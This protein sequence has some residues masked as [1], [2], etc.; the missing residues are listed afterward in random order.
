MKF[1][2]HDFGTRIAIYARCIASMEKPLN[3]KPKDRL[4]TGER[5]HVFSQRLAPRRETPDR[6]GASRFTPMVSLRRIFQCDFTT[7][8]PPLTCPRALFA[9]GL[10]SYLWCEIVRVRRH[11][12]DFR[13]C[14]P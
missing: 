2:C 1:S 9:L 6:R 10:F 13:V 5:D 7:R 12:D 4:R 11:I 14:L 8:E 3:W